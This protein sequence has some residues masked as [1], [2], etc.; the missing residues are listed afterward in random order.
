MIWFYL[1]WRYF[2]CIVRSR[3]I[4]GTWT[5]VIIINYRYFLRFS[6]SIFVIYNM[7]FLNHSYFFNGPLAEIILSWDAIYAYYKTQSWGRS[8]RRKDFTF[9]LRDIVWIIAIWI[10][11]D[12]NRENNK[13]DFQS[14]DDFLIKIWTLLL[15]LRLSQRIGTKT[16]FRL[17][18]AFTNE[19]KNFLHT[20]VF[21]SIFGCWNLERHK[22]PDQ[23]RGERRT[24]CVSMMSHR[25]TVE[26]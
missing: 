25:Y 5:C 24:W 8:W 20:G 23:Q 16:S 9:I 14:A 11:T 10:S 22:I 12:E 15:L 19:L 21:N 1:N 26:F 13:I 3:F 6:V 17:H 18:N 4:R 2:W 7:C